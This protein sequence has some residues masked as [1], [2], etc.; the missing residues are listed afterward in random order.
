MEKI[1]DEVVMALIEGA[2]VLEDVMAKLKAA[3][4]GVAPTETPYEK[5][6]RL[7]E[8]WHSE[9]EHGITYERAEEIVEPLLA[10]I[11]RRDREAWTDADMVAVAEWARDIEKE[12][13]F[14]TE[15]KFYGQLEEWIAIRRAAKAKE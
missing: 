2:K 10:E 1:T 8:E 7:W 6:R 4:Y 14:A 12:C 5:A 11:D 9:T 15:A 13:P 3:G